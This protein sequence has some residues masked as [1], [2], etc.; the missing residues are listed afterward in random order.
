MAARRILLVEDDALLAALATAWL[1]D[2]GFVVEHVIDG[3]SAIEAAER[4]RPDLVLTDVVLP[5][6]MDG[7]AVTAE[8]RLRGLFRK[9]PV[10]VMSSRQEVGAAATAVGATTFLRKPLDP[11][12]L[13]A[14]IRGLLAPPRRVRATAGPRPRPGA[15]EVGGGRVAQGVLGEEGGWPVLEALE[16]EVATGL[17]DLRADGGLRL[18]L[19][20]DRGRLVAA[21]SNDRTTALG[22]VLRGL[23]LVAP[24]DLEELAQTG[25]REGL[26]LGVLLR[27][28]RLVDRAGLDRALREQVL[29][30][31]L[32]FA[33]RAR[34]GWT[35]TSGSTLGLGGYVVPVAALRCRA[36]RSP[37]AGFDPTAGRVR[38]SLE[39]RGA[40]PLFDPE[41]AFVALRAR[42]LEG[43]D[44]ADAD[45]GSDAGRILDHLADAGLLRE[46]VGPTAEPSLPALVARERVEVA[47]RSLADAPAQVLLDLGPERPLADDQGESTPYAPDTLPAGVDTATRRRAA[48]LDAQVR[49]AARLL[50]DPDRRAIYE[51]RLDGGGRAETALLVLGGVPELLA[52]R[53]RAL[54]R[55]GA[56]LGACAL[57]A[58]ATAS[59]PVAPGLLALRGWARH[60]ACRD[61]PE[62]GVDDLEAARAADPED[63]W[64]LAALASTR[65]RAGRLPAARQLFRAALTVAPGYEPAR[66]GLRALE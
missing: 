25:R 1:T 51:A 62:A 18:R 47:W 14:T 63:P 23:G 64:V 21:R 11:E 36:G 19:H 29:R 55:R 46:A 27:R 37:R 34:G 26:P 38:L 60:L 12:H 5:G 8:L 28:A 3:A 22:E 7:L 52:E 13:V 61:D 50:R 35:F 20:V 30:R 56:T 43:L 65:V 54:L 32:S 42:L 17:L 39:G 45:P 57:L 16:A 33:E 59:G 58:E 2:E 15:L 10:V 49:A 48:A 31:A 66:V 6:P 24:A 44:P 9:V 4:Q 53:A 41:D 40:W